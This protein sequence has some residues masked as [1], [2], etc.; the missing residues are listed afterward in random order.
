MAI[1]ETKEHLSAADYSLVVGA[2]RG[3]AARLAWGA[4]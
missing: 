2:Q 1:A 3:P 4:E